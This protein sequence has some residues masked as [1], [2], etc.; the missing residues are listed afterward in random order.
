MK[1]VEEKIK[2]YVTSDGYKFD[3]S[4][5]A[6]EHE[7]G[8]P[9]SNYYHKLSL[10][11]EF[12]VTENHLK[13]VRHSNIQWVFLKES[14]CAGYFYQDFY[15]PYGN[16]DWIENIAEILGI[17][18]DIDDNYFSDD[19]IFEIVKYHIDM[20][21]VVQILCQNLSIEVGTYI[22]AYDTNYDWMKK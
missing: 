12:E 17:N 22:K 8:I 5:S 19:L 7:K 11:T 3:D 2:K 18:P 20:I 9:F 16:S 15:R 13:L 14:Y 10:A 21:V 6:I 4:S 1:V